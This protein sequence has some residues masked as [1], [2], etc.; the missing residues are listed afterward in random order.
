MSILK[1]FIFVLL[2][3]PAFSPALN[4]GEQKSNR[5][6]AA[7]LDED[8]DTNERGLFLK[9]P[10]FVT[11]RKTQHYNSIVGIYSNADAPAIVQ[12]IDTAQKTVDIE[13]YEMQDAEVLSAIQRALD[14]KVRVR[15]VKDPSP[16]AQTCNPFLKK[17]ARGSKKQRTPKCLLEWKTAQEITKSGGQFVAFNKEQLCGKCDTGT[18]YQHGKMIIID[19]QFALIS[20]GNFNTSSLCDLSAKPTTCNRDYSYITRDKEVV[21]ALKEIFEK[22][23]QGRAYNLETILNRGQLKDKI[24]VSPFSFQPLTQFIRSAKSNIQ[25]QNQYLRDPNLAAVIIEKAKAG[26]KIEILLSDVCNYGSISQ[27]LAYEY[28]LMFRGLTDAGVAVKMF[29]K[30]RKI[31]GRPGYLH[32]K[33]IVVD[34]QRAWIGSVNGS[35]TSLNSNR[36]FG[37]FFNNPHRVTELAEFL[38][39]DFMDASNYTWQK[40]VLECPRRT[41]KHAQ[42]EED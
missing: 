3:L 20:T 15:V 17:G 12:A 21:L 11:A 23:L 7:L 25:I 26:V 40:S 31:Q 16:V 30:D 6:P 18:C 4:T 42:P 28:D 13:I 19:D 1:S 2:L 8:A 9:T 24:T 36:E 38:Q 35:S 14:R 41:T 37:I 34:K 33:A 29:N 27:K 10:D 32:A 22:D 39:K 5:K